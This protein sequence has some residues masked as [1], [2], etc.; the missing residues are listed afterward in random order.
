MET[1][2]TARQPFITRDVRDIAALLP[3][4]NFIEGQRAIDVDLILADFHRLMQSRGHTVTIR[5]LTY[6][7]WTLSAWIRP[8]P[9][10]HPAVIAAPCG[11]GKSTLMELYVRYMVRKYPET[12]GCIVI[13][14][15][16]DEV[17]AFVSAINVDN[18]GSG[19]VQRRNA[20]AFG[21]Y[22]FRAEEMSRRDYYAQFTEQENYP[23]VAMTKEMWARQS[24]VRN[25]DQF[26]NFR[27]SGRTKRRRTLLLIDERPNLVSTYAFTAT[28]LSDLIEAVRLISY[29]AMGKDAP[30]YAGFEQQV[31]KL[32]AQLEEFRDEDRMREYSAPMNTNYRILD[33]LRRD[34]ATFYD[35][36]NY[37]ALGLFETAIQRGGILSVRKGAACLTVSYR[38]FYEWG[39]FNSFILDA[40]AA[41]DPYYLAHEFGILVPT[42]EHTFDNV[43]FLV[44]NHYNLSRSFFDKDDASFERVAEMARECA[45]S[46]RKTMLVTYKEN[47]PK[48]ETLLSGEIAAGRIMLKHFDSGRATNEYRDC[49]GAIFI[50]WLLKGENF[51]PSIASAIYNELFDI[52]FET[53]KAR[54]FHFTD[55]TVDSVR[56]RDM[57]TERVQ[58]IHRLRPRSTE[59][60]IRIYIFHRDETLISDITAAFPGA[61]V[62]DFH[63]IK[64]LSGGETAADR[65][66]ALFSTMKLGERLKSVVIYRDIL[67]VDRKTMQR[68]QADKLVI[69]AMRKFGV[70]RT[71]TYYTKTEVLI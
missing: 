54:G 71:S 9:M 31:R 41:Q 11:F 45:A 15:K 60:A 13:K 67:K 29:R 48:F 50:G 10:T 64:R 16:R 22:G 6:A 27:I 53:G 19:I 57:V 38:I 2:I 35:G 42:E 33:S 21:V 62:I 46:S 20:Y 28:N 17:A 70:E 44:N 34:W 56:S 47:I 68:A 61:K 65:L 66:I 24:N 49:D 3:S 51:Y 39:H 59:E 12:F 25:I 18:I 36:D 8:E 52:G 14:D 32:R 26:Q 1:I 4:G 69:D 58:D 30:Y 37:D 55:V 40:T 7:Y 43:T 5:D 23:V 63:P